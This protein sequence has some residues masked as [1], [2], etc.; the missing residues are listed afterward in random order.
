MKLSLPKSVPVSLWA[1]LSLLPTAVADNPLIQTRYTADPAPVVINGKVYLYTDHDED[2]AT[3]F[4]MKDWRLYTS[5]DMVNWTD[6]GSPLSLKDFSW[7]EKDA[8]APQVVARNGKFY[9]YA[10]M[11]QQG[12]G[13]SVGVAVSDS[14]AGPFHDALGHPLVHT[15]VGDIDPTVF[16][17]ADGQAY[18]YWGNPQ[19]FYVKL[20]KDMISYDQTVGIVRVPLTA[21]SFGK[22]A[23]EPVSRAD[24]P[25]LPRN[26]HRGTL[27][28]EGP[29]FYRRGGLYYMVN[30]AGGIPEF[31]AYSTSP[32]PTGPWTYRGVIMPNHLPQLAFTNH[33]G[34]LDYKGHSYFFYHNQ[35]LPGGGGFDRSVC[36]EE[37]KYNPDGSF[38][39]ILPTQAGPAPVGHLNP[40]ETTRAATIAWEAGVHTE[41]SSTDGVYVTGVRDGAYIKVRSVDF[42]SRGAKSLTACV[43]GGGG[44][45]IEVRLDSLDGPLAATASVPD[46]GGPG[47]WKV[48]QVPVSGAKGIHDVF[49]VFKAGAASM[50]TKGTS[51]LDFLWWKF[52]R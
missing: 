8:W 18:L 6:E 13:M 1:L 29:W 37:F 12:V 28:V 46:T 4:V 33:P 41:T 45:A 2:N 24:A 23:D 32:S 27:Y 47:R 21:E 22:R 52:S 43:A 17:D 16:I 50:A 5:S 10:P 48:Q 7:A 15:G 30:A 9:C 3:W 26:A 38:P 44:A 51:L 42:G 19:L 34:V 49:F 14:P 25:S 40:Y 36:V 11:T 39:T 20:N 35:A 31:I